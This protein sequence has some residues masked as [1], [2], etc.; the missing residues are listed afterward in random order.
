MHSEGG[1]DLVEGCVC[2]SS[3]FLSQPTLEP[4]DEGCVTCDLC[5][6]IHFFLFIFVLLLTVPHDDDEA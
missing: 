1:V 3:G 4:L 5:S 6:M 2:C